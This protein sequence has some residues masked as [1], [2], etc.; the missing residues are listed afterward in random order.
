MH[1]VVLLPLGRARVHRASRMSRRGW[2]LWQL[3]LLALAVGGLTAV[4]SP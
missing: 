3:S 4:W 1:P 2:L